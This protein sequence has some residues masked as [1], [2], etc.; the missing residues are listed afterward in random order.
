MRL[1]LPLRP[2]NHGNLLI[3]TSLSPLHSQP[4]LA[5]PLPHGV[6]IYPLCFN[7]LTKDEIFILHAG[8][9]C[10]AFFLFISPRF[11]AQRYHIYLAHVVAFLS[12]SPVF[13]YHTSLC[14]LLYIFSFALPFTTNL[15]TEPVAS[16]SCRCKSALTVLLVWFVNVVKEYS[17]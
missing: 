17:K 2:P 4:C 5:R 15:D 6:L 1:A 11:L 12:I 8:R 7:D 9:L 14:F 13:I 10:P 3:F 16:I